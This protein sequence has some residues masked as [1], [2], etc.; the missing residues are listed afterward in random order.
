MK[1]IKKFFYPIYSKRFYRYGKIYVK[2]YMGNINTHTSIFEL[3]VT[4]ER[5]RQEKN[6]QQFSAHKLRD[7]YISC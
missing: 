5:I 2:T 1:T 3:P 7:I 6:E 4:A